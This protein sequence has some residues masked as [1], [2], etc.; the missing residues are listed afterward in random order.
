MKQ[1]FIL[2][3]LGEPNPLERIRQLDGI[4][5]IRAP[6]PFHS[7]ALQTAT[8]SFSS[9][10]AGVIRSGQKQLE[11][12]RNIPRNY[13]RSGSCSVWSAPVVKFKKIFHSFTW[14]CWKIGKYF[15]YSNEI[16]QGNSKSDCTLFTLSVIN[17]RLKV[18][19]SENVNFARF[20][21]SLRHSDFSICNR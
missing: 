14:N 2:R 8:A 7:V 18:W 17:L 13:L 19:I 12:L 11:N 9:A 1:S 15:S 5:W 21:L 3:D 16:S 4:D 20:R 10:K 6:R